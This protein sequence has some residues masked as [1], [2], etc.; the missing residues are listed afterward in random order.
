[1]FAG[2]DSIAGRLGRLLASEI[3]PRGER[4]LAWARR[5][6]ASL[7]FAFLAAAACGAFIR[8]TAFVGCASILALV[9]LGVSWPSITV[10]GVSSRLRFAA[11]RAVEGGDAALVLEVRNSWP[12]PAWALSLETDLGEGAAVTLSSVPGWSTATFTWHFRAGRRGCHP[13]SPP[14][15]ATGFPFGLHR[16]SR[17]CEVAESLLVWPRT[18][19]LDDVPRTSAAA[20]ALDAAPATRSGDAGDVSGT[21]PFRPGDPLRRVHWP[22][23]AR[24]GG[25]VVKE[26]DEDVLPRVRITVSPRLLAGR[27]DDLETAIRVAASVAVVHHRRDRSVEVELG[28]RSLRV[29]PGP[30]GLRAFLDSLA[31]FD[32]EADRKAVPAIHSCPADVLHVAIGTPVCSGEVVRRQRENCV[33]IVLAD[34]ASAAA[35]PRSL[36]VTDG[37][38]AA[39]REGWK[40]ACHAA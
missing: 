6:V 22:L 39:F 13:L 14:R 19:D 17:P 16:A 9:V 4:F 34:S 27:A 11:G 7:V 37:D 8:P 25:M 36:C 18:V 35:V 2:I 32:P 33:R 3:W 31:L 21:R 15:L 38:L 29:A 12:W 1:M 5:P 28:R 24:G 26:R 23:T 10:R 20:A 40:R 30:P